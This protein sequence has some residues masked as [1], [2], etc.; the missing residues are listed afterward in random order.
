MWKRESS[1]LYKETVEL[2]GS[3]VK[4]G[5]KSSFAACAMNS[6]EGNELSL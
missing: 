5:N 6:G 3:G 2:C 4:V 1:N